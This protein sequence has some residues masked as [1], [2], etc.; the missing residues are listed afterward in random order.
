MRRKDITKYYLFFFEE[1][2]KC[3]AKIIKRRSAP[4]PTICQISITLFSIA[5]PK[6]YPRA[7]KIALQ[8]VAPAKVIATNG[9]I[10]IL[11][12][13]AGIEIRWRITGISRPIKVAVFAF[14]SNN[15]SASLYFSGFIKKYF[16]YFSINGFPIYL[17]SA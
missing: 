7:T 4:Y 12:V 2:K 10:L 5:S 17:P 1:N 3:I 14:F 6:A 9:R 15:S 11:N 16:P 13:P 8:S